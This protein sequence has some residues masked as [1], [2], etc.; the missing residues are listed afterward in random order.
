MNTTLESFTR[1]IVGLRIL[2]IILHHIFSLQTM[3][4][5]TFF[6]HRTR[7]KYL[8]KCVIHAKRIDAQN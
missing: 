7:L 8:C 6:Q 4:C 3:I 5:K 2:V 1:M